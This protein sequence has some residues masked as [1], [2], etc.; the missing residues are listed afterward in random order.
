MTNCLNAENITT[1]IYMHTAITCA[2]PD[3]P[4]GLVISH[5]QLDYTQGEDYH[6]GSPLASEYSYGTRLTMSCVSVELRHSVNGPRH[7]TC[8]KEGQW[9]HPVPTC[10]GMSLA[11]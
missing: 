1:R 6:Y 11:Y 10:Q 5:V 9:D 2:I 7:L 3:L 4:A 8:G